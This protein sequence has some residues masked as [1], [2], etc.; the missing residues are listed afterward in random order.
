MLR[1]S[2]LLTGWVGTRQLKQ[3]ECQFFMVRKLTPAKG[4]L[5]RPR[6]A[7]L[8]ASCFKTVGSEASDPES[9]IMPAWW[10]PRLLFR[11]SAE[12]IDQKQRAAKK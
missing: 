12:L 3:F 1:F 10:V 7:Y 8:W 5:S 11:A 4:A 2:T 9:S 6:G